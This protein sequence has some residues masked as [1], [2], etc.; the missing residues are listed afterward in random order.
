MFVIFDELFRGTNV[1]D[2]YDASL[3]I[4]SEL[5]AIRSSIFFISTHLLELTK[6][7]KKFANISFQYMDVILEGKKPIF[8]YKLRVGVSNERLGMYF[9]QNEGIIELIKQAAE[10]T[11]LFL[12]D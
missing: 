9:I 4:I 2:A 7:L 3:L 8:T 10:N 5:A 12:K 11:S 1:K 6:E